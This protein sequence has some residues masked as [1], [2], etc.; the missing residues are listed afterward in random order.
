MC[1]CMCG[2]SHSQYLFFTDFPNL[3]KWWAFS[4]FL[5]RFARACIVAVIFMQTTCIIIRGSQRETALIWIGFVGNMHKQQR[6]I[7]VVFPFDGVRLDN[8]QGNKTTFGFASTIVRPLANLYLSSRQHFL[9]RLKTAALL[10]T[11]RFGGKTQ[12]FYIS[13]TSIYSIWS[14]KLQGLG[15]FCISSVSHRETYQTVFEW[16]TLYGIPCSDRA[17]L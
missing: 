3:F 8:G 5:V 15:I 7:V 10:W 4:W 16:C 17:R 12:T 1:R 14:I 11:S 2:E 13:Y 9:F 6:R